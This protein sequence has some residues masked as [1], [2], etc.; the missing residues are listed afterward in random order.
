METVW[1]EMSRDERVL[2]DLH[3]C[4]DGVPKWAFYQ[5][6]AALPPSMTAATT[7]QPTPRGALT[8]IEAQ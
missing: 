1:L 7:P 3:G 4:A 2:Y 8:E 6:P 5:H